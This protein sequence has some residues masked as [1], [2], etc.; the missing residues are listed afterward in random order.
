MVISPEISGLS[1]AEAFVCYRDK[2]KLQ[3]YPVHPP[4]SKTV[5]AGKHPAVSQWWEY[6]PY[7][8]NI[9]R[10]FPV[11]GQPHNIGAAPKD[12]TVFI[13]LDSKHDHGQSAR[14]YR[15]AQSRLKAVPRH[16]SQGGEHL[17]VHCPN[18]PKWETRGR[19]YHGKIVGKLPEGVTAELFIA[20]IKTLSCPQASIQAASNIHGK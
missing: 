5:K 6:D 18:L 1:L 14:K 4:T 17:V 10:Y 16:G 15:Q 20:I 19:P 12:G 11:N 7:G 9:Q 13:D 2:L 8:C 3:V